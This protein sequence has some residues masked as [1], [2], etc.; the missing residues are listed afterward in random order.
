MAKTN[1]L[2]SAA[3]M[4]GAQM[5]RKPNHG[6]PAAALKFT[7]EKLRWVDGDY[8]P[9]GAYWGYVAGTHIYRCEADGAEDETVTE[10]L[11]GVSRGDVKEQLLAMYPAARFR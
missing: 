9:G 1:K 5:G 8:D 11:R 6:D 2:P 10:W 3:S 7:I 4:F